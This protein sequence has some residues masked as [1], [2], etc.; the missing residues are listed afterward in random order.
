[1][2]EKEIKAA[3]VEE[4]KEAIKFIAEY[5]MSCYDCNDCDKEIRKWCD[6]I[7]NNPPEEWDEVI[8]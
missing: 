2:N 8:R 7:K 4:V 1:M 3:E 5:C 6:G